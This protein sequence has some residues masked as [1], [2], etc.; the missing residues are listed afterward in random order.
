[1]TFS[2]QCINKNKFNITTLCIKLSKINAYGK[3][4][5]DNLCMNF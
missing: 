3:Y 1:M 5:K 4:C 2:D